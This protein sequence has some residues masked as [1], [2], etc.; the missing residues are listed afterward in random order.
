[1]NEILVTGASGWLGRHCVSLLA[2]KGYTVHAVSRRRPIELMP[3]NVTWHGT[4]LLA[5]GSVTELIG[6][7]RPDRVLHLAWYAEPGKFWE[8]RENLEWVRASLE[9]LRAFA[10]QGG[11][12]IVGAG[13]CAEY[14]CD[15]GEC[16]EN[17]TPLVPNTLYGTSKHAVERILHGFAPH[18]GLSH[19]WGRIFFLYGPQE[20]PS[21]LVA[22]AVRSLLSG[23]PAQCSDGTQVLDFLHVEDAA[24]AFVALLESDVQGPMNIGSGRPISV[25]DV[26][27]EIGRQIGRSELIQFGA[28]QQ[29]SGTNRLWANVRRLER[30][31]GWFPHFNLTTGIKQTIEWWRNADAIPDCNPIQHVEP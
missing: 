13:S 7:V 29:S 6:R 4:D 19:A 5:P 14:E 15:A 8:A 31:T 20:H 24:S 3:S 12:R 26:L 28:I 11:K 27:Q 10:E 18:A 1:M 23:K 2:S 9:L 16:V 30:E 17:S 22:Y 25:R 21:R